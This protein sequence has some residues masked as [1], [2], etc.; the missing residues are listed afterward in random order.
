MGGINLQ[1]LVYF[2]ELARTLHYT[3]AARKLYI[4][5]P[6]LSYAISS[7]EKELGCTLFVKGSHNL[8]LS[9][10]G[11]IFYKYVVKALEQLDAGREAVDDVIRSSSQVVSIA[12]IYTLGTTIIPGLTSS[13]KE[14][15]G[16]RNL[17]FKLIHGNTT[18]VLAALKSKNIDLAF[19]SY[20]E[21]EPD[22][23]F[24]PYIDQELVLICPQDH[25]LAVYREVDLAEAAKY[26]MV[27]FIEECSM[28]K[29][30]NSMFC[31]VGDPPPIACEVETDMTV[32][33]MVNNGMGFAVVPYEHFL[34][35]YNVRIIPIKNPQYKLY[36]YLAY[37]KDYELPQMARAFRDWALKKSKLDLEKLPP[38]VICADRK[39]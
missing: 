32:A 11:A 26:P 25:P 36:I 35:S 34:R 37:L 38:Q 18:N 8:K 28:R 13:F 29:F 19:C 12:F 22:V 30:I 7:L 6:S 1:H 9:K 10:E 31:S 5:Q 17:I 16:N 21:D 2:S 24:I 27:H 3:E 20:V 33:S 14:E 15:T 23:E 4:S 39:N